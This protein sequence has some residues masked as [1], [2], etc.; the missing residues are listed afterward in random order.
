MDHYHPMKTFNEIASDIFG[1]PQDQIVDTLASKDIPEWDSINYLR[2]ISELEQNFSMSFTMDE[3]MNAA[4]VGDVRK[5][6]EARG[7]K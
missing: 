1:I 4:T 5:I 3:V 2:F 6:V 7:K